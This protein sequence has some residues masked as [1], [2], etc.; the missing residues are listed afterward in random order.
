[1]RGRAPAA[2]PFQIGNRIAPRALRKHFSIMPVIR[3]EERAFEHVGVVGGGAWG[4]ALAQSCNRAGR[5]V[6][7]WAHEAET[8]AEINNSHTNR[9]FLPGV[10]LNSGIEAT[11]RVHD[12]AAADVILLVAPAQFVRLVMQELAPYVAAETPVVI[13]AKGFEQHTGDFM[14]SVVKSVL[15]HASVAA[16]SGPSFASEV[17]RNL[18]AA[19]TLACEEKAIGVQLMETLAHRNFRLYWTN[20]ILG[21][22]VGSAV[23]NV[24]AIATGI[25]EG[26]QLGRNAHAALTTRGFAEL[27]RLG[28]KLGG[29]FETLT[30]LSGLGDL[31]LTC[32]SSQSRNMSLG[33]ALGQGQALGDILGSRKSVSEGVYSAGAV[34][35]LAHKQGIEM[36]ICEAVHNVVKG[37]L[38]VDDAIEALLS[39]P[40]RAE[41]DHS[42]SEQS[43]A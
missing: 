34:V 9:V 21:A 33:V 29:R 6:T 32:S 28:V 38:S 43:S 5:K 23:K 35:A 1:L 15:P 24:L 18:P 31:I 22:Q 8:V 37:E 25:V 3:N 20:D 42:H 26:R 7:L 40:L 30:G 17:A 41:T 13:C 10:A 27:T 2:K 14:S 12:L 19:L 39:R 16:L 36:P 11:V 4:T